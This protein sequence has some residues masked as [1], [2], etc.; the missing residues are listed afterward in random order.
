MDH[1]LGVGEP[2]KGSAGAGVNQRFALSILNIG[3]RYAM[4]RDVT[5]PAVLTEYQDSELG[6]ADAHGLL[7]RGFKHRLQLTRRTA[8]DLEDLGGRCLLLQRLGK[9]VLARCELLF[10][11]ADTCLEVLPRLGT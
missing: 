1:L 6:L 9:L 11:L 8:D 3:G 2:M 10:Q 4:C 7:E 5:E